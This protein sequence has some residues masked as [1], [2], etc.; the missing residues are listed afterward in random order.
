[1][2]GRQKKK[3]LV[4][5]SSF[6]L[7]TCIAFFVHC[8]RLEFNDLKRESKKN[9]SIFGQRIISEWS[10]VDYET[11][12]GSKKKKTNRNGG[13]RKKKWKMNINITLVFDSLR[14]S[15]LPQH[16]VSFIY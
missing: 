9:E 3:N 15:H 14:A 11:G 2:N 1:M 16:S 8:D 12:D 6:S 4:T 10:D 7:I 13:Q 5:F